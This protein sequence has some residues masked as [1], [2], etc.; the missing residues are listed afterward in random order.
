MVA[1]IKDREHFRKDYLEPLLASGWVEMT[2]PDKPRSSKQRYK[3]TALGRKVLRKR[4]GE[5]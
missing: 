5:K 1:G 3:T 4:K 2:I